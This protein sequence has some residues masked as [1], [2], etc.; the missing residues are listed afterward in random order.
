MLRQSAR[1]R[2]GAVGAA[3][4]QPSNVNNDRNAASAF[5][6]VIWTM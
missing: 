4:A 3:I 6:P 2:L 5:V 1:Y